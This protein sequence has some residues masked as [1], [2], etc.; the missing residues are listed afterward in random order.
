[1]KISLPPS[2]ADIKVALSEHGERDLCLPPDYSVY[3]IPPEDG[4]DVR[5]DEVDPWALPDF[6][7]TSLK[8]SGGYKNRDLR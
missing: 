8:L 6:Q 4:G 7:E 2:S 1:M 5:V 3:A